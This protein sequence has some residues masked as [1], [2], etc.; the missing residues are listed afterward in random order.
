[1][2][3]QGNLKEFSLS[4]IFRLIDLGKKSG[5]LVIG[6]DNLEGTIL[7]REGKIILGRTL[8]NRQPLGIRLVESELISQDELD[9]ALASQ[10]KNGRPPLR[11][12]E[13]L[14]SK[15]KI[16]KEILERFVQEQILD[17]LFEIFGW[18]EGV[19]YFEQGVSLEDEDIGIHVS[20]EEIIRELTK[21]Y[22]E[23]EELRAKLPSTDTVLQ[24]SASPGKSKSE[25][26]IKPEEWKI[27]YLLNRP[28]SIE[29]LKQKTRFTTL[30]LYKILARMLSGGL[31]EIAPQQEKRDKTPEASPKSASQKLLSGKYIAIPKKYILTK[32]A[33]LPLEW[34]SYY[35][36]LNRR[37]KSEDR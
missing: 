4:E 36:R 18:T 30:S 3:L 23:W 11:L 24:L 16:E 28:Q 10:K 31:I 37:Q 1:M 15:G 12:G 29:G 13:I 27:I 17:S 9:E 7:F 33:D 6:Q 35:E 22:R 14:I 19:F 34:Q 26:T 25:I 2:S 8:E 21:R 32:E 20:A 5:R